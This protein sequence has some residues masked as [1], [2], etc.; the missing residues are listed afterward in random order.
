MHC[1]ACKMLIEDVCTE[2]GGVSSCAVNLTEERA[3]ITYEDIDLNKL[4]EEIESL[5][6]Y[7]VE[8]K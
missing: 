1:K 6:D 4:K 7:K 5:G 8:L 3:T 2:I